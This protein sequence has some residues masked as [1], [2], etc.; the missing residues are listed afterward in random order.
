MTDESDTAMAE[1]A[2]LEANDRFYRAMRDGDFEAM[3]R[4][5]A[6]RRAVGCTHPSMQA[7]TGRPAVMESWRLILVEGEPPPIDCADP[8]VVVTGGTAMVLC[9]E[10]VGDVQLVASNTFVHEDGAWR[11]I[12][13]QAAHVPG[14]VE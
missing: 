10:I 1:A 12:N 6:L 5:W 3:D 14:T 4:L 13:H 9:T 2:V 7:L 8:S 11:L